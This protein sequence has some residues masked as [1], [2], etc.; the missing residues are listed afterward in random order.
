MI[1]V[2]QVPGALYVLM[3][4]I[5]IA[6]LIRYCY[7]HF[8]IEESFREVKQLALGFYANELQ[9]QTFAFNHAFYQRT[10][11]LKICFKLPL[12][13]QLIRCTILFQE[14]YQKIQVPS[15]DHFMVLPGAH[16][17]LMVKSKWCFTEWKPCFAYGIITWKRNFLD[18]KII[19]T[20]IR[21]PV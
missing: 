4:L 10:H 6:S 19:Y 11:S 21:S 3:Y 15:K 5:L 1:L 13:S 2:C 7:A 18:R 12:I 17:H 8:T 9:T 14:N 20:C 16:G